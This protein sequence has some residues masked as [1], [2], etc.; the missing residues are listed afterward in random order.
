MRVSIFGL[1]ARDR[2]ALQLMAL[3]VAHSLVRRMQ[4]TPPVS[5]AMAHLGKEKGK[6]CEQ[7]KQDCRKPRHSQV[8]HQAKDNV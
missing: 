3:H 1:T 2:R 6:P 5:K 8:P 4:S 7:G